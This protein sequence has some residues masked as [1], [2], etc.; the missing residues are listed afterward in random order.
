MKLLRETCRGSR[1]HVLDWVELPS[2]Q[3]ELN[4]M[5]EPTGA[6]ISDSDSA[7]PTGWSNPKEARLET[8]GPR[9]MP[10]AAPWASLLKWW[11]RNPTGANT[12]NWDLAATCRI[13][14]RRGL[15]LVEAKAHSFEVST[16]GKRIR[17][18]ASSRSKE[19]H[20]QIT[21]AIEQAR[22][23]LAAQ[24]PGVGISTKSSYQ[25]SNRVAHAWWLAHHG[26]PVVLVYLAFLNDERMADQGLPIKDDQDWRRW[27][28][29]HARESLPESFGERWLSC[30][31]ASLFLA[32]R[33]RDMPV[34]YG[35][36]TT[37]TR[38]SKHNAY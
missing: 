34:G 22:E 27:F 3:R 17:S 32:L 21:N 16:S 38:I 31:P 7:M 24:E 29:S 28:W 9:Y 13:R 23:A 33:A 18:D 14:E 20:I 35:E 8:F 19:N 2:F 12:P 36:A 1:R 37:E 25:L 26:I 5:L 30:G 4:A 15:V 6:R 11:L 10:D